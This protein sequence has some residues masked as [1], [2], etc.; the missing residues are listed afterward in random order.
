VIFAIALPFLLSV[1]VANCWSGLHDDP[2][3][4]SARGRQCCSQ[5]PP[6]SQPALPYRFF[7]HLRLKTW[8]AP[9]PGDTTDPE[10]VV[11]E[12]H[13]E[14]IQ[15]GTKMITPCVWVT[16]VREGRIIEARDYNGNAHPLQAEAAR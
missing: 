13:Y 6:I 16:R 1:T 4:V 11:T 15:N 5:H 7:N 9:D 12:F 8:H 14:T 2:G 10:L 3:L